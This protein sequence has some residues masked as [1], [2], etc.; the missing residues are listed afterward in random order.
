MMNKL[1]G[2]Y[3][4]Q[5]KINKKAYIGSSKNVLIRWRDGHRL[6]LRKNKHYNTYLQYAWN[7]DGESN[8]SF[9]ILFYCP[10][11][12]LLDWEQFFIDR[13]QSAD[14]RFGYN[15]APK[16]NRSQ[17]SEETRLKFSQVRLGKK[18]SEETKKKIS[19]N[20]FFRGKHRYGKEN[21]FYGKHFSEKSKL[22]L[23][24]A[25]NYRKKKVLKYDKN[26]NFITEYESIR[27]A[28][29]ENNMDDAIISRCC[30]GKY[31]TSGGF[32]WKY[33]NS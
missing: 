26:E 18:H 33:K 5:N 29:R 4:I 1:S 12:E 10:E 9:F 31:K 3:L 11:N 7:K 22:L 21:P 19:L 28:G 16:A 25:N 14:R 15:I 24:E 20:N 6:Y 23:S 32:I 27:Q 17:I 8:F 30:R 2:I 13:F